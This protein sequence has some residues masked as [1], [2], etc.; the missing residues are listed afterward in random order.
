MVM[1]KNVLTPGISIITAVVVVV[2]AVYWWQQ[3]PVH[4]GAL[5][6]PPTSTTALSTVSWNKPQDNKSESSVQG[7]PA[8]ATQAPTSIRQR[9]RAAADWYAVAKEILPQAK[10]GNPEAQY[11]LFYTHGVCH[12]TTSGAQSASLAAARDEALRVFP[13]APQMVSKYEA[14]YTKCHGFFTADA[15]SLGDPW[16]WLQKATDTGYAPAQAMT[17]H[18][19]IEQDQTKA[20]IRAGATPDDPMAHMPPIGGDAANPRDLLVAA[21]QSADPDV[22]IEIGQ[23]QQVLNPTQPR[24]VM[25]I[26]RAA[27]MYV[28]CQRGGD[29][30]EYGPG[31]VMNCGPNDGQCTPVPEQFLRAVNYNWAPVQEKINQ[32]NA[33]L[34]AKQWDQ[35]N[36]APGG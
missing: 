31:T 7:K 25:Q 15:Q 13:T 28:G 18:L 21:V 5:K 36:I 33:A 30:S 19:R 26:N 34:N 20:A 12:I 17:A 16:D 14:G 8:P 9:M 22:L 4:Q 29:C 27:W 11:V 10:A 3:R 6:T 1:Q 23:L 2:A 32:I 24:D 35:L